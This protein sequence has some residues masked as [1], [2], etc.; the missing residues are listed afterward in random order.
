METPKKKTTLVGVTTLIAGLLLGAGIGVWSAHKSEASNNAAESRHLS[1]PVIQPNS[2]ATD[3]KSDASREFDR[4][5]EE[6]N[7]AIRRAMEEFELDGTMGHF[8][9]Q[10]GYSSS[11]DLRD[12]GDHFEIHAYLP[13]AKTSD[14]KVQL[15]EG[16]VLHLS[17]TQHRQ[18]VKSEA[19]VTEMGRY[20][21]VITLPEAVRREA[22]KIDRKD[23]EVIITIPKAKQT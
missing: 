21:E 12:R 20:E 10:V 22:M 23:D 13:D 4:L 17:A 1:S 19:Q 6:I 2:S 14:L 5:H 3:E 11:F 8:R 9:P 18:E 15:D 7:R 16:N